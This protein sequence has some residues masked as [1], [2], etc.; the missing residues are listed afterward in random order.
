MM[1]YSKKLKQNTL[2]MKQVNF[3]IR[4]MKVHLKKKKNNQILKAFKEKNQI[5][6]FQNLKAY[7]YMKIRLLLKFQLISNVNT[8]LDQ[9]LLIYYK[10]KKQQNKRTLLYKNTL[11]D[12]IIQFIGQQTKQFNKSKWIQEQVI[13][14]NTQ[15]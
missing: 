9:T 12:L 7:F 6:L 2:N 5:C 8:L 4:K 13:Q 11:I 10:Q 15:I 14:Q 1:L 3:Q